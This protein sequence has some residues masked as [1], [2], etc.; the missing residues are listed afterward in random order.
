[1]EYRNKI[2]GL[3][4][5]LLLVAFANAEKVD[6]KVDNLYYPRISELSNICG[7]ENVRIEEIYSNVFEISCMDKMNSIVVDEIPTTWRI[8]T[9]EY[10]GITTKEDV[11]SQ[12][13]VQR[14][15]ISFIALL[16]LLY[17]LLA[18]AI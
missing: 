16:L 12:R 15:I 18:I 4:A 9:T 7:S 3:I 17:I 13:I 11:T 1:M 5:L 6:A 8:G 14:V 2:F 10:G